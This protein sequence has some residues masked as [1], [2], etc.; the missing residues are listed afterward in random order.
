[1][2]RKKSTVEE[3]RVQILA[4][5]VARL[6]ESAAE[7]LAAAGEIEIETTP[8][9]PLP[10]DRAE[11]TM[12]AGIAGMPDQ[13]R[14]KL[15]GRGGKFPVTEVISIVVAVADSFLA[16]EEEYQRSMEWAARKLLHGIH[17]DLL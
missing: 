12:L 15:T 6:R 7:S 16:A 4:G 8:L 10:L 2:V 11:R 13:L 9:V 5:E 1:M 14:K 17:N 3:M